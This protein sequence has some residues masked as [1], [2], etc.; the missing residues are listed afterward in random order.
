MERNIESIKQC[1]KP[2][3]LCEVQRFLGMASYFRKFIHQFAAKAQ[4]LHNLCKKN[5]PFIW[6]EA[7]ELAFETLK[8]A[9]TTAPVLAFADYSK[10]FYISVDA[11]FHAVGG[12]IS[13]D[14]PPNDKPIEYFSKSLSDTQKNYAT[15]HKELLAIILGLER[16][17]H[18][19]YG[20][21]FV[22]YTDHEALTYL[23]N[24]NKVGSRLTRWK[25]ELS[26]HDFDV[27][28]RKGS[29]NIVSDCL[30]RFDHSQSINFFRLIK[31]QATSSIFQATTRNRAKERD[32][33]QNNEQ[34]IKPQLHVHEE[35]TVTFDTKK[36]DKIVFIIDDKKSICF[37][38]LQLHIKKK[39]DLNSFTSG[40]AQN[41]N[42]QMC[43]ILLPLTRFDPSM[44]EAEIIALTAEAKN[45]NMQRMAVN[46]GISNY[47]TYFDIKTL[48]R[49]HLNGSD[50]E[51]TFHVCKQV[52]VC[53]V[54]EMN[55]ILKTYHTSLLGAHRGFERM[56]N[57]IKKFFTWPTMNSD[58]RKFI[59]N[60]ATCERTK[61]HKHI[62]TPL[63]ITS[64]AQKPFEKIYIDFVG[65]I[66]PNSSEGHKYIFTVSCDLTKYIIMTP[67]IDQ[68][69]ITAAR[70]I[71]DEVCLTYN[72]PKTIVSDNG[73]AFVSEIFAQ[74]SKLLEIKHIK[75]TRYHPQSNGGIERYHRT[76]G[77]Y[78]RAYAQKQS[79]DWHK[80]V[81][82]FS[83]S[84]N[85]TVHTT[86]GFA[87]HT[88]VFGY[89]IEIPISTKKARSSYNYDS[90][91]NELLNQL[92][93]MHECA[94]ELI[95][96][97]KLENK[98]L[99][100]KKNCKNLILKRNDL[101]LLRNCGKK[102]GKF[103]DKY[104]GPFRVEEIISPAVTKIKKNNK[105]ILVHNDKLKLTKADYGSAAPPELP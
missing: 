27:I 68:T 31:N 101:V 92:K 64:V 9:L 56:N 2:K 36:Y 44:I 75:T 61:I 8:K 97:R 34:N 23:F 62:H 73:P 83:F 46:S 104:L 35:P 98:E 89:D 71:V 16:F 49:Q 38:K 43:I 30:S 103:D 86:T 10:T 7:C 94:K 77:Q 52:E 50:V 79:S 102:K 18:Y 48:F 21:K 93:H 29:Q 11:S 67:T 82:Y 100:D 54:S 28:H 84:Y 85:T 42:E 60:C 58:I 22:L 5:I 55:E 33:Q 57:T 72:F 26:E 19:I 47:R 69:A 6:D 99:Y 95:Q 74:M 96:K 81:P 88:L 1:P 63:Q 76:L 80:Y 32:Q 20:K 78:V 45:G 53:D 13:N 12:Y 37:K 70:T 90:Y 14:P 105:Y 3:K 87:P 25:L 17:R 41:I 4:P 65:E 24:Q 40:S 15:T 59:E 39:I 91:H 66:N 51:L